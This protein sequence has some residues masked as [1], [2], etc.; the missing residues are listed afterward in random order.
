MQRNNVRFLPET[1]TYESQELDQTMQEV[2]LLWKSLYGDHELCSEGHSQGHWL[3]HNVGGGD[4]DP[5][6]GHLCSET[7]CA[8]GIS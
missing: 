3:H 4:S 1:A 6:S 2:I 5:A 8:V 7:Q